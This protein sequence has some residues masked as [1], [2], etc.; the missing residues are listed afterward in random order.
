[1]PIPE[2]LS[3]RQVRMRDAIDLPSQPRQPVRARAYR[4]DSYPVVVTRSLADA[5][6]QVKRL[7]GDAQAAVITDRIVMDLY[8][9][10][11]L[12]ALHAE[13]IDTVQAVIP[14]GETSKSLEQAT[15]LWDWLAESSLARRD[16]IVT[17]GGGVI[18][19]TGGW[20]ASGY[21]RGLPYINVPTTLMAQVDGA[22]GGK[23][24][25]NHSVAKN[26][27]GAFYQP[28]GVVSNVGFLKTLDARHLRAGLAECVKKAMIASPAYWEFLEREADAIMA[29]DLDALERLVAYASAIKTTLIERD[30]YEDDLRR[31]LNFGHTVGHPLETVTSYRGLLHGEAVALGM[32]VESKIALHRGLL[33]ERTFERLVTLLQR[34]GL[35]TSI[36]E[37]RD[38]ISTD[39]VLTAM[40]KVRLIRAGHLR[41]VL[42]VALGDTVIA[43][44]ISDDEVR[45]AL[46]QPPI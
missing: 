7:V 46:G 21:M 40:R 30:P 5:V 37:L 44:D 22:I 16:V 20:V 36:S 3:E 43:D 45:A 19:D 29:R 35:P 10:I 32:V 14:P 28:I 27:L 25:V 31:P 26:L 24:A 34:V 41:Y 17:F 4:S 11:F 13:G 2:V 1:V 38:P 9:P 23:V 8:G 6:A 18:N 12:N 39:Q 42:P 33:A 15:K